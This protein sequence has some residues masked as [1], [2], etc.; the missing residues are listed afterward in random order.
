MATYLWANRFGTYF[1]GARIPT[2]FKHHFK[3]SF[4]KKS[5]QTDSY[6]LAKKRAYTYKSSFE[7]MLEKLEKGQYSAYTLVIVGKV[8]T[9]EN[10]AITG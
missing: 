8:A 2:R 5:L 6:R 4:F 9:N 10:Q 1:F 7:A 3:S